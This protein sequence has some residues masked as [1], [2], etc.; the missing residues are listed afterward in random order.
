MPDGEHIL[1]RVIEEHARGKPD[2]TGMSPGLAVLASEQKNHIQSELEKAG[3]V[4]EL[5]FKGVSHGLDIYD[6]KFEN[7]KMEW[8]FARTFKGKISH[9]YLRPTF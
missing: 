7:A 3:P 1:R 6:V 4:K 8:G 2:I 5:S 9:L